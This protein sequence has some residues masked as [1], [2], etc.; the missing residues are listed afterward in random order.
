VKDLS[1]ED[2]WLSPVE[3]GIHLLDAADIANRKRF[4]RIL[5][6]ILFPD[7]ERQEPT[8][9]FPVLTEFLQLK[10]L[11]LFHNWNL[12]MWRGWLA[13]FLSFLFNLLID[14]S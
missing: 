12:I 11:V 5:K 7:N 10:L 1:R 8:F 2:C 13:T 4:I 3:S 9:D 6:G 14:L